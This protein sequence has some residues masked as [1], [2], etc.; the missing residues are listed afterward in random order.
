[1]ARFALTEELVDRIRA[2]C[3]AFAPVASTDGALRRAAVGI[4][5]VPADDGSDEAA[6]LVTMRPTN[7]RAHGG[8]FALPGGKIDPGE[9]PIETAIR[10]CAEELGLI[11]TPEDALGV[12]DDYETRSGYAITP[13]VLYADREH[14]IVPNPEE[15]AKVHHIG[16]HLLTDENAVEFASIEESDRPLIRLNVLGTQVHAP[17]AAMIY[18]FAELLQGRRTIVSH[19]EQPVFAWK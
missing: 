18:Q 10:E 1:M 2:A 14:V 16:L 8:Q 11:L 15:V 13:V 9:T 6:L 7:M 3:A 5:L 4:V 12:L 17:T 19:L